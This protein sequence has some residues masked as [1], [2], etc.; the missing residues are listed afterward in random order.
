MFEPIR[1]RLASSFSRNGISDAATETS[2]F[3]ETSMYSISS[4]SAS[5]KFA[6]LARGVTFVDDVIAFSSS[7]M[8]AWPMMYLSSSQ[9]V[10]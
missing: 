2:C 5:D 3:G 6:G 10:R 9:A 1:A 7:S 4:R 8:L